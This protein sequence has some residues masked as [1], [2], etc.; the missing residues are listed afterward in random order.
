MPQRHPRRRTPPRR[1]SGIH[2]LRAPD[3]VRALV[4]S[5][6]VRP[7]DHVLDLGAGPG[8]LTAALAA[9]GAL[10]TAIERDAVFANGLRRRF[11]ARPRVRVIQGDLLTVPLP[12]SAKVVAN[13]P[14]ATS[15]AILARLLDPPGAP[16]PGADLIV[17]RGFAI[18]V[19]APVPRSS[20]AAWRS[21]RYDIRI[22]RAISRESFAPAPR[23]DAAHLRIRPRPALDGA[24]E[25]RLRALLEHAYG[26]AHRSAG[27]VT[28]RV[29]GRRPAAR[30]LRERGIDW[31]VPAASIPAATW[32]TLA[33][34]RVT[35]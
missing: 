10:I 14:F 11:A 13:L 35:T 7:G 22:A 25:A 33:A 21:A 12:R 31:A 18:R 15:S 30:A 8:A 1:S 5:A 29:L 2:L 20:A 3:V 16:R 19:S 26:D 4:R 23:V 24:A 28:R 6:H 32:A 9:T 34:V 17:E 27:P